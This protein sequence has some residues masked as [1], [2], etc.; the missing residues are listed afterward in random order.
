MEDLPEEIVPLLKS[1]WAQDP[2]ARPEFTEI[3]VFLANYLNSTE[4]IR[5]ISTVVDMKQVEIKSNK[6]YSAAEN[7]DNEIEKRYVV[8]IEEV[9]N[10]LNKDSSA[11]ENKHHE[12]K[13]PKKGNCYLPNFLSCFGHRFSR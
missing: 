13:K 4:V 2:K 8:K 1:C 7:K 11:A 3:T 10:N 12:I 9:G 6:D 5:P